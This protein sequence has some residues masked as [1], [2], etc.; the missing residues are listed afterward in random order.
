MDVEDGWVRAAGGIVLRSTDA[1]PEVLVVHRPAYDDWTFPKGKAD[2]GES[3]E[4]CAVREVEEETGLLCEIVEPFDETRYIDPK[5][6]PKIVR[7]FRMR[8]LRGAFA[9]HAEIDDARWLP[10]PAAAGLLT[11]ERDRD[12]ISCLEAPA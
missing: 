3:D 2:A 11:Y 6:R 5:G 8:P 1:G 10:L 4:E 12:L 7:Y 9:P